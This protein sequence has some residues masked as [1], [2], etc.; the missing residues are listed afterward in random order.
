MHSQSG[1]QATP[2]GI[3]SIEDKVVQQAVSTVRS[4]I[5]EEDSLGFSYGR[6]N[7]PVLVVGAWLKHAVEGYFGYY[8]VPTNPERLGV[9]AQNSAVDGYELCTA[10]AN[11]PKRTGIV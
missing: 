9:F 2:L 4:M 8:A 3:A 6:R 10:A 5:D 1:W 7:E 11:D